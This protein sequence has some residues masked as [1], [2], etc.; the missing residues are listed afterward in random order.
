VGTEKEGLRGELKRILDALKQN[1]MEKTAAQERMSDVSR[2][3]NRLAENELQQIEPR[4]TNARKLAELMEEKTREE[5][6]AQLE[7]QAKEAEQKAASS[8]QA[9]EKEQRAAAEAEK[10]AEGSASA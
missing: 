1:G 10:K 6:K 5:R 8:E 3:V 7:A 2:E 4:L 9:A